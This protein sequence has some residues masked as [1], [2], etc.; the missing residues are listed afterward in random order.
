MALRA[1]GKNE[2]A[3]MVKHRPLKAF[4][5]DMAKCSITIAARLVPAPGVG[6]HLLHVKRAYR[7]A[8]LKN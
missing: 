2:Q 5:L 6:D 8:T 4:M 1:K 3:D 7:P